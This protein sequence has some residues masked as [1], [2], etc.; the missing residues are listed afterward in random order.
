MQQRKSNITF[1]VFFCF[2]FLLLIFIA[3][4]S[5]AHPNQSE[6]KYDQDF[7]EDVKDTLLLHNVGR[8]SQMDYEE[9]KEVINKGYFYSC[10]EVF[11]Y[12]NNNPRINGCKDYCNY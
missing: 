10:E 6:I 2:I 7:N 11:E 4:N 8:I 9:A 1:F 5:K 12:C 3:S